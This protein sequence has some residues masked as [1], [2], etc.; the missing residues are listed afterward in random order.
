MADR[1]KKVGRKGRPP[2]PEGQARDV[3]F[4]LRFTAAELAAI[5]AAADR[6]DVTPRAWVREKALRRLKVVKP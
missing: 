3:M 4:C 5:E 6:A 2:L 1:R